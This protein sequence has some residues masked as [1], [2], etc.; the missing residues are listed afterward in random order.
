MSITAV[1]ALLIT[2]VSIAL[3]L[4]VFALSLES[5]G[6]GSA[7][8]GQTLRVNGSEVVLRAGPNMKS[9]KL[10]NQKATQ[11]FGRTEYL[12]IESSFTVSEECTQ[13][14]WSKV[15][16]LEP[17]YLKDSNIGWVKSSSLRQIKKDSAG[18]TEFVEADFVWNKKTSSH[19][20]TI[21]AGVNKI[22]RENSHCKA[23]D[24]S[25]VDISLGKGKPTDPVFYVTCRPSGNAFNVFFSKSEIDKGAAMAALN[26][27]DRNRAISLCE[28]HAKSKASHP[29]SF[30]F[31]RVVDLS[32]NEYPNGR[33][34]VSSSFT[35]KNS[36]N[37]E[38]KHNI[39]CLFD[40]IALIEV[41]IFEVK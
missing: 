14:E 6:S 22:H 31:S 36:F 13:G 20:K 19:K 15:K 30:S 23:I 39:R 25:S 35:V 18:F 16:V 1:K 40:E 26:H 27:I 3:H 33:T 37:L 32:V 41:N 9:E 5:C 4:E 2:F 12:T 28:S 10:I 21:I 17:T 38:L 24:P 34:A 7:K 29:S 11:T 8:S